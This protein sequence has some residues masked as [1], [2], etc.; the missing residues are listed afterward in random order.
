MGIGKRRFMPLEHGEAYGLMR[1]IKTLLDPKG[2]LNPGKMF[3]D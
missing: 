2:I 1:S 3:L